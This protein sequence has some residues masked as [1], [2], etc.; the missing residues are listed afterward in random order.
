MD[1]LLEFLQSALYLVLLLSAFPLLVSVLTGIVVSLLQ[2]VLQIQE[3][4][5]AFAPKMLAVGIS[6]FF[7]G[8]LM[9]SELASFLR[10]MLAMVAAI[11]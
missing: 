4:T 5:L 3:S 6:L 1:V 2:N 9:G 11:Q 10:R 7:L 8:P